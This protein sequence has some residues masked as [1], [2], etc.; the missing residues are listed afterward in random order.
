MKMYGYNVSNSNARFGIGENQE[1]QTRGNTS[2]NGSKDVSNSDSKLSK[3]DGVAIGETVEQ[4][5]KGWRFYSRERR[6]GTRNDI[7]SK[8][9]RMQ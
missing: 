2:T 6:T 4:N 7:R 9:D 5:S 1:I 8:A 3:K